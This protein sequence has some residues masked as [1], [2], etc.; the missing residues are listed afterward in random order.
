MSRYS[1][2]RRA[3]LRARKTRKRKRG[4]ANEKNGES[5]VAERSDKQ[6]ELRVAVEAQSRTASI[7]AFRSESEGRRRR[8]EN[9]KKSTIYA[10]SDLDSRHKILASSRRNS[11]L[12][13]F[14]CTFFKQDLARIE[15]IQRVHL[16]LNPSHHTQGSFPHLQQTTSDVT[17]YTR[18]GVVLRCEAVKLVGKAYN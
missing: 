2:T 3:Q 5:R 11:H 14:L 8:I 12:L 1:H 16:P 13:P 6:R 18:T 15:E 9:S 10:Q 17:H 4:E 7:P